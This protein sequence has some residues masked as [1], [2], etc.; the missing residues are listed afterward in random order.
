MTVAALMAI[1]GQFD[2]DTPVY[3]RET[4]DTSVPPAAEKLVECAV[5]PLSPGGCEESQHAPHRHALLICEKD[6]APGR[7]FI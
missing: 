2:R 3:V 6:Y 7:C 4:M 1:L 5:L